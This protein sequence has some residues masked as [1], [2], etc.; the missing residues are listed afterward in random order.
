[1][2]GKSDTAKRSTRLD[3]ISLAKKLLATALVPA[4]A[5]ASWGV[6]TKLE[7]DREVRRSVRLQSAYSTAYAAAVAA[8]GAHRA[9]LHGSADGSKRRFSADTA[10]VT[11]ALRQVHRAGTGADR[12]NARVLLTYNRQYR[13]QALRMFAAVD[14]GANASAKRIAADSVEPMAA[15]ILRRVAAERARQGELTLEHLQGQQFAD[16]IVFGSAPVSLLLVFAVITV[17]SVSFRRRRHAEVERE[18]EMT[19]LERAALTDNLTGLRNHRAFHEDLA[20]NL[21]RRSVSGEPL[22]LLMVDLDGLKQTNDAYGH[23]AGDE[24]IRLLADCLR[25]VLRADDRAYRVGGDEFTI[26]L[27]GRRAW[28]AFEIGQRL[29]GAAQERGAGIAMGVAE[30]DGLETKDTL[31]RRADLAL[32]EAKRSNRQTVIWSHGLEP[33]QRTTDD[34]HHSKILATA[35]ARAVDAKDASTRNHCETVAELCV[36]IAEELGLDGERLSKLRLA[37]LLHD[38]G[39]IG[40]ADAILQKPGALDDDESEIM[41]THSDIGHNIISA[42]ELKDEALWVLHHH[43]RV[44]GTGYPHGL[45]GED[46]PLE[47]RIILVADTYEAITSDRP[48]RRGRT[49]EEALAEL[50]RHAGTQFDAGCVAALRRALAPVTRTGPSR[51]EV[52]QLAADPGSTPTTLAANRTGHLSLVQGGRSARG[53]A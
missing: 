30:A 17:S 53:V 42:A 43:E 6:A 36:M 11:A 12:S 41:H 14:R 39:K 38:V 2:N 23:Q 24:R 25:D 29:R 47:S 13:R 5:V 49:S 9:I 50:E 20:R 21:V 51:A 3:R 32:I 8:R 18:A 44:D 37:G 31:I 40:I 19:R 22:S 16:E 10:R 28:T 52:L 34:E 7:A 4:L 45:G 26:I 33:A 46:I 1:M 35:L 27:P 15:T 48:Y